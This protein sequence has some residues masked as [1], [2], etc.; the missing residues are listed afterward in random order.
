[1]SQYDSNLQNQSVAAQTQNSVDRF[2]NAVT[3]AM[4]HPNEQLVEQAEHSRTHAKHALEQARESLGDDVMEAA[5][6]MMAAEERRLDSIKKT[7]LK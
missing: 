7:G 3:Q 5:E 6:E 1:M 4:S 2:H